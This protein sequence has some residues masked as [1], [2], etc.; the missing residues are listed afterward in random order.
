MTYDFD[1]IIQRRGTNCVKWD[2]VS[3]NDTIPMWVADMDF[4]TAPCIM[5]ALQ[6][7]L[8]HG[9]FGYTLVPE[10]YY[11][12][13]IKWFQHRHGWTIDRSSFIYTS[14]V[15]PAISAIIKA[16]TAQLSTV[17]SQLST[18]KVLVQTP[19]YNCFFSS[20]RNNGC[21]LAENPLRMEDHRYLIDWDDFEKNCADPAVKVFLLCNPHNPAGRVWTREELEKMGSICLKHG[22]F[23]ISDEIHCEFTMPGHTYTPFA[24]LS[25]DFAMN[26]AVCLSPSKAFNIAGLQIANIIVKDADIRKKVDKAINI[27]EVCDVNPFGVIALQAAYTP[28]GEAWLNELCQYIDGN[29]QL[30]KKMLEEALPHCPVTTLE[31]TYLLW[32]NIASTGKTSQQVADDLMQ[33]K[34]YV[35]SGT[36]Y[37]ETAGEGYIR[38]NLATRRSLVE[39]GIRRIISGIRSLLAV[40]N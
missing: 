31:G 20:I 10:S 11:D 32:L 25:E 30:A 29:Y 36:M 17:N 4:E 12:A 39:E 21:V 15:V 3:D 24:S 22:V 18:P 33:H 13:T 28:E 5:Q 34:V 19:V 7:R 23:V 6:E 2:E 8:Q 14:G 37:G 16:M 38:I 35:N 26:S 1:K 9:C 27:N 40:D